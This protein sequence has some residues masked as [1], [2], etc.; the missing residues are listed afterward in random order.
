MTRKPSV[1]P[2][3]TVIAAT[4]RFR[5]RAGEGGWERVKSGKSGSSGRQVGDKLPPLPFQGELPG[6]GVASSSSSLTARHQSPP[7]EPFSREQERHRAV[8][9][10][11]RLQVTCSSPRVD[12][13]DPSTP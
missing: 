1:A 13:A 2:T 7:P 12:A 3:C 10:G 9:D 4:W 11:L 8:K 6:S 5:D